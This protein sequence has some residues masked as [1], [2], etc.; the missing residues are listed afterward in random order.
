MKANPV[1]QVAKGICPLPPLSAKKEGA[2]STKQSK[3]IKWQSA[4][5]LCALK[6]R[7]I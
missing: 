2:D 5:N 4:M 6:S 1:K 7:Y 3:Q